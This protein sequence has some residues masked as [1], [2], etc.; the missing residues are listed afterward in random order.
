VTGKKVEDREPDKRPREK[1]IPEKKQSKKA[2]GAAISEEIAGEKKT[3]QYDAG[4]ESPRTRRVPDLIP[5]PEPKLLPDTMGRYK[6][7]KK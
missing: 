1:K 5:P 7:M 6:T 2:D 3:G 4:D